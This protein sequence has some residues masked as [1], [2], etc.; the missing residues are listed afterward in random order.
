MELRKPTVQLLYLFC[1]A[2]E[3]IYEGEQKWNRN[4]HKMERRRES[5]GINEG[6]PGFDNADVLSQH[7]LPESTL[8]SPYCQL[9]SVMI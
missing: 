4:T 5:E 9:P 2:K 3:E 7:V 6:Q 8:F 1:H